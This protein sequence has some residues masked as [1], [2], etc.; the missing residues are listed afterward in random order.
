MHSLIVMLTNVCLTL[1]WGLSPL[2]PHYHSFPHN[3]PP[4]WMITLRPP[5]SIG[6]VIFIELAKP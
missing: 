6:C 5:M 4:H 2:L 3:C 1:K